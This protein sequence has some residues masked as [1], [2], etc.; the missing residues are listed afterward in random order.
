MVMRKQIIYVKMLLVK[1][2]SLFAQLLTLQ[3][4]TQRRIIMISLNQKAR[5]LR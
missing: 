4:R 2:L 5:I 3:V 1:L